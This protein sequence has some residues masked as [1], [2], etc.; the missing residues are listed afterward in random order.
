M[1]IKIIAGG[2][3]TVA[4]NGE[5]EE[6]HCNTCFSRTTCDLEPRARELSALFSSQWVKREDMLPLEL[7]PILYLTCSSE[8]P[9]GALHLGHYDSVRQCFIEQNSGALMPEQQ[10]LAWMAIPNLPIEMQD[11]WDYPL[12]TSNRLGATPWNNEPEASL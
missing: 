10:V 4:E 8:S 3:R 9:A 12:N 7:H 5:F 11:G 2:C 1:G 6:R